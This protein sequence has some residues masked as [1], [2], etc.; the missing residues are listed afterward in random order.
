MHQ[1]RTENKKKS[2]KK[3]KYRQIARH[4]I[5]YLE[6]KPIYICMRMEVC[7]HSKNNRDVIIDKRKK[8]R[9]NGD[10]AK[11]YIYIC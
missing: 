3:S 11:F 1:S 2:L 8:E 5:L 10:T 9:S 6:P 4:F 7:I